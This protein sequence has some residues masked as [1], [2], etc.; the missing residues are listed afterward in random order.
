MVI[1]LRAGYQG[2]VNKWWVSFNFVPPCQVQQQERVH[3]SSVQCNNIICDENLRVPTVIRR[4]PNERNLVWHYSNVELGRKEPALSRP[5]L[6]GSPPEYALH[7]D[8]YSRYCGSTAN[9]IDHPIAIEIVR[10]RP[11][12]D[13]KC[14]IQ[15]GERCNE[16]RISNRY[17]A[18][19]VRQNYCSIL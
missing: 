1:K 6:R 5:C 8:F 13:E 15:I 12:Y 17:K 3:T 2:I 19:S 10:T 4:T 18:R 11:T 14:S 16:F 9:W 7:Q